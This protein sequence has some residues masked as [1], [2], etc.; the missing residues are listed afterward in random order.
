MQTPFPFFLLYRKRNA[1][2]FLERNL[3]PYDGSVLPRECP[4]LISPK[5]F[6]LDYDLNKRNTAVANTIP[7]DPAPTRESR[8][9]RPRILRPASC[10]QRQAGL[11]IH[12]QR[13]YSLY[14]NIRIPPCDALHCQ[15]AVKLSEGTLLSTV[16]SILRRKLGD[17][18]QQ[19]QKN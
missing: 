9:L 12:V 6:H 19:V 13:H 8:I 1:Q 5:H 15:N 2:S 4:T 14:G 10:R 16:V 3:S 7:S 18:P 17:I 11:S